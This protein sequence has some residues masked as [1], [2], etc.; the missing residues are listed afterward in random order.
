MLG[1]LRHKEEANKTVQGQFFTATLS[2]LFLCDFFSRV[3]ERM[4]NNK[5][6]DTCS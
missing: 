4:H 2:D 1:F 3:S 5:S 6:N